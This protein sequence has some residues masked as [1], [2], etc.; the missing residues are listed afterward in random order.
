MKTKSFSI[1]LIFIFLPPDLLSRSLS[2]A[3][4]GDIMN[5]ALQISTAYSKECDCW[6]YRFSFE[7]VKPYLE[8]ADITIGNLETTLPGKRELYSGYPQFGAP[9]ELLDAL[10]WSGFDILTLANNHS[11]DK[12]FEGLTR[13]KHV[14]KSKGIV[15]L[16]TYIDYHDF[17]QSSTVFVEKH[18]FRIALLNFTYGTNG[19][20]VPRP[21]KIDEIE[22]PVLQKRIA[23]A[24]KHNPDVLILL[25]HYGTEYRTVPDTY[26][27]KIVELALLEGTDIILGG[28]PHVLQPVE[29]ITRRDKYG[30][31]KE[32]LIAWS[33]GNFVSNQKK[34]NT[35]GGIILKFSIRKVEGKIRIFNIDYIP[36]YVDFHGRHY[37]LPV[38]EYI[39]LSKTLLPANKNAYSLAHGNQVYF[40][41]FKNQ[42]VYNKDRMIL[43]FKNAYRILGFLPE[44]LEIRE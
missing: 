7:K 37:I 31:E 1:I 10:V 6:D 27:R 4:V 24:K 9:D 44:S 5:H 36:V 26:Q 39:F 16:G 32:R 17:Q 28:H 22:I 14:T 8:S 19:I 30:I 3:V 41:Y 42:N 35:D 11:V 40:I 12:G 25:L 15:P 13:T 18:D 2:F 34:I 20:P 21:A 29:L 33:L 38:T 43:F 23:E